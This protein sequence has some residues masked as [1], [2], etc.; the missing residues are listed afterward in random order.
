[1][2]GRTW[3]SQ[4][5]LEGRN[6][7]PRAR[8]CSLLSAPRVSASPWWP[9]LPGLWLHGCSS[10]YPCPLLSPV[11]TVIVQDCLIS[12]LSDVSQTAK[13]CF[14]TSHMLRF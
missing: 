6:P 4:K 5:P 2:P 1:M 8:G 13:T 3:P 12:V 14:Q 9:A 11:R 7:D 10:V